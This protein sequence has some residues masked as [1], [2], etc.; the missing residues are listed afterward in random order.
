M[1]VDKEREFTFI[2]IFFW[3]SFLTSIILALIE[4]MDWALFILHF[5]GLIIFLLISLF[6]M[7]YLHRRGI[8]LGVFITLAM[9]NLFII[10]PEYALRVADFRYES[11]IQFGYPRPTQFVQLELDSELFWKLN[12]S[13]PDV[14]SEGFPGDEFIIPKPEGIFRILYLGDSCTQ[15]GYPEDVEALLNENNPSNSYTFESV[16]LAVSGYSSHQGRIL[17]EKYGKELEPDLVVIYYG[18][19]DHWLAYG[20][21]DSEKELNT[22]KLTD[23]YITLH[24]FKLAQLLFSVSD[25]IGGANEVPLDNVRVP[26]DQYQENLS[27]ITEFFANK[28]VPVLFITA[29]T[30]HY[31]LGVPEYLVDLSF[32]HDTETAIALHKEYNE[33]VRLITQRDG[34]HLLDLEKDFDALPAE[35]LSGIFM[36]DGIHFTPNGQ[37]LVAERIVEFVQDLI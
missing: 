31:Q 36:D 35:K 16:S 3:A 13:M 11:G 34:G 5:L 37:I 10:V 27:E 9:L 22:S 6:L 25:S 23:L 21:T 30:S 24:K 18:W 19:N 14:N 20:A 8:G 7:F 17:T 29:P 26:L 33:T 4:A 1:E 2:R 28:G 12:P 15:H 32:V